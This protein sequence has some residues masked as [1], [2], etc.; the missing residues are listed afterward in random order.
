MFKFGKKAPG[1]PAPRFE[2]RDIAF[3]IKDREKVLILKVMDQSPD[4]ENDL[5][6]KYLVRGDNNT[7]FKLFE[8]ELMT[9][10]EAVT[11]RPEVSFNAA[12]E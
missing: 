9:F 3:T 1:E 4:R 10:D 11:E 12:A 5:G 6:Y 7:V 2:P 8:M